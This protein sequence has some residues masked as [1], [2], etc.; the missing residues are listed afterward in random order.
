MLLEQRDQQL[1]IVVNRIRQRHHLGIAARCEIRAGC[2]ERNAPCHARRE[3]PSDRPQADHEPAGHVFAAVIAK[4]LHDRG[5]AAVTDG[6]AL[7]G[8]SPDEYL[9]ACRAV[10]RRVAHQH[11]IRP[12][13]TARRRHDDLP[14]VHALAQVIVRFA[15]E[16]KADARKAKCA[17]ALTCGAPQS[18]S[19][20]PVRQAGVAKPRS[21]QSGHPRADRAI[22]VRNGPNDL[23]WERGTDVPEPGGFDLVRLPRL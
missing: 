11:F 19:E 22:G 7:A 3:V 20:R 4:P 10:Q 17:E 18:E 5:C 15:C 1:P 12:S 23:Q 2:N 14:A 9:T 6:E 13:A 16:V 21:Y 8:A